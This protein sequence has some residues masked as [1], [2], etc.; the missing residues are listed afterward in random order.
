[1]LFKELK[2]KK[3]L[4]MIKINATQQLSFNNVR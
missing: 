3:V 4:G 1:M 2:Q